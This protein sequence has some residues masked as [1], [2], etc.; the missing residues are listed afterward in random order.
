MARG[1]CESHDYR[2]KR[3]GDPLGGSKPRSADKIRKDGTGHVTEDGYLSL[4]RPGHPNAGVNGRILEHRLVMAEHLG[5]SL[6]PDERVHH[7]NGVK[8]DNRIE[9][10]ELWSTWHPYGQRVEDLLAWAHELIA[11]YE[12]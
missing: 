11:R 3:Y 5:R 1:L 10:L 6:F 8:L 2:L 7:K 9:N 12:S 4:S